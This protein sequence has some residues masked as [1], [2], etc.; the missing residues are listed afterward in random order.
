MSGG[1]GYDNTDDSNSV[2]PFEMGRE[3]K[4]FFFWTF[5]QT[6]TVRLEMKTVVDYSFD[7]WEA[8]GGGVRCPTLTRLYVFHRPRRI[9]STN[10]A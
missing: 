10:T 3:R 1:R 7:R 4:N 9:T 5:L 8:G 2:R 6:F